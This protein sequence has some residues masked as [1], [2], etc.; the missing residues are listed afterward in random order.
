MSLGESFQTTVDAARSGAQWAWRAIY[1]DLAPQVIGYL[2]ANG[3]PDPDDLAGEVFLRLVQ[4]IARFDGDEA[5]FRSWVF[6]IA[7]HRMIDERRR[8]TRRPEA[9]LILETL[10]SSDAI[11]DVEQEALD[12][13]AS[14]GVEAI[15]RRCVPDQRDVLLLRVIAGLSLAETADVV[16][17]SIGAVKALQRRGVAAIAREFTREGV[18]L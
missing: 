6:V 18:T 10:H 13:L 14:V 7:H 17:K 2:R 5:H 11:G 8:R 12:H 1:T 3:C 4:D 9:P 15:I 16:G